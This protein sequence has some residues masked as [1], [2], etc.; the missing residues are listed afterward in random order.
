MLHSLAKRIAVLLIENTGT[1]KITC[2]VEANAGFPL[3]SNTNSVT[4]TNS[5][6][7]SIV[8]FLYN[9]K[10]QLAGTITCYKAK[11]SGTVYVNVEAY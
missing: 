10:T 3:G 7:E 5:Y 2:K 6:C 4:G 8:S 11:T 1:G 9:G